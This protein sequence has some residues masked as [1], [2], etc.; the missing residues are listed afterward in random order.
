VEQQNLL[1]AMDSTIAIS[2]ERLRI[3]ENRFAIGKASKL[4]VLNVQVN[5]NEDETS[6][7]KQQE[8]VSSLKIT[9][10][11]LLARDLTT[12][13]DV[14]REVDVDESLALL[15]LFEKSKTYNPDLLAIGISKRLAELELKTVKANRY[16][17]I[18]LNGG[19]NFSESESSLGFTA[20]SNS[21]GLN[22]GVTAS[23]NIFDGFNQRRSERVAKIQ[24]DNA[25]IMLQQQRSNVEATLS[26]A[27]QNY[28]TNISLSRLEDKNLQIAKQNLDIT[29]EK[30][31]IGT[32]SPVEFR[33]A[34]E[35]YLNAVV[36]YNATK[37]Q[38]KLSEAQLK[39][40]VGVVS[41]Q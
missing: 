28:Q 14:V 23:L 7:V 34:Q 36:R 31:R 4:D 33:D 20:Q 27:F 40:I 38:A 5:L 35:N 9:L 2:E 25:D 11:N 17:T 13:F 39:E 30:Y 32:I 18:R 1:E 41:L 15:D 19:Y 29:M 24:V 12:E 6:K 10:N 37:L 26:Q 8:V 16:P 22:Y 3:A 21:R